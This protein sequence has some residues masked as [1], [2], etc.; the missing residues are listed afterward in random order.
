MH[1][2]IPVGYATASLSEAVLEFL[3]CHPDHAFTAGE[4]WEQIRPPG[5]VLA[6][7]VQQ[8]LEY[9]LFTEGAVVA[10]GDVWLEG[11]RVKA[12]S[13]TRWRAWTYTLSSNG[14]NWLAYDP[15]TGEICPCAGNLVSYET[16]I[17]RR[18]RD[19]VS[20][21]HALRTIRDERLYR[22]AGYRSFEAYCQ[23]RWGIERWR[24]RQ[25]IEAVENARRAPVPFAGAASV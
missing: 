8:A 9:R 23:E 19:F 24:A 2:H 13:N 11:E 20:V 16:I 12:S 1:R 25:M 15:I 6:C 18:L 21:S 22:E 3:A 14:A 4:L 17:G 5:R 7:H 10:D